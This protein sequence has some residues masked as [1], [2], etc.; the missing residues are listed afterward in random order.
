MIAQP[1]APSRVFVALRFCVR[2][3]F[4]QRCTLQ[5]KIRA[6]FGPVGRIDRFL[7]GWKRFYMAFI[8]C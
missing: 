5:T 4:F 6:T 3:A 1:I 8:G 7:A 2:A